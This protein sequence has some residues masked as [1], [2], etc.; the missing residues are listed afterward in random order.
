MK[1]C[2]FKV[3]GQETDLGAVLVHLKSD[4][5]ESPQTFSLL[6]RTEFVVEVFDEN[7]TKAAVTSWECHIQRATEV[8]GTMAVELFLHNLKRLEEVED[9]PPEMVIT[10]VDSICRSAEGIVL[11]GKLQAFDVSKRPMLKPLK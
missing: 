9:V 3:D 8:F 11:G 4:Q 7:Q 6:V 10:S 5:R 2:E 1:A